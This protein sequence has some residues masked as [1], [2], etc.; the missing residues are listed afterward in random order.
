LDALGVA[1]T[2]PDDGTPLEL[3]G[4]LVAPAVEE[5][6]FPSEELVLSDAE[7]S[8]PEHAVRTSRTAVRPPATDT[9]RLMIDPFF[10]PSLQQF[11][12]L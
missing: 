2:L 8:L 11:W 6:V 12:D 3:D 4:A 5:V 1:L 9:T 7:P 10:A